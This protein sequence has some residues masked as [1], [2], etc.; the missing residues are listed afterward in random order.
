M[1][2]ASESDLGAYLRDISKIPL[3]KAEEE[4]E[5]ATRARKGDREAR[6]RLISSNLRLVVSIAKRYTSRGLSLLDLIEEGN[7]G[8]LKAVE[9]FDPGTEFRFSTYATWWIKQAIRRAL[10]NTAKTVR[11][12]AYMVELVAQWKAA[13]DELTAKLG[14]RP[15]VDQITRRVQIS[16]E[17]LSLIKRVIKASQTSS[18]A[19]SLDMLAAASDS[20]EDPRTRKPEQTVFDEAEKESIRRILSAISS[21][22]ADVLSLRY[23]L[24]DRK[25][26][27]LEE[28]GDKLGL[29][30]ERVRQ[31]ERE[32]LHKLYGEMTKDDDDSLPPPQR[33]RRSTP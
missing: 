12:P 14:R 23:G 32:A 5:L 19:V 7:L 6:E 9:R 30:R 20:I 11:V 33:R 28:I 26:M 3:L 4:K 29:T 8:L 18:Q 21:R 16:P 2:R 24:S 27:T 1:A 10:T 15:T 25:P 31:I 13:A 22:E 17:R